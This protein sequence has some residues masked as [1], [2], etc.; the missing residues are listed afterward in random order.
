MRRLAFAPALAA[1]AAAAAHLM[2]WWAIIPASL[3]PLAYICRIYL[4][5]K[6][7]SKALDKTPPAKIP[8]TMTAITAAPPARRRSPNETDR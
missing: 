6:L 5:Y 2:T 7:A 8:D 4:Q 3:G 1:P